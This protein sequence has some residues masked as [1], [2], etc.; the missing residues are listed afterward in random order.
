MTTIPATKAAR[1]ALIGRLLAREAVASQTELS[2]RLASH[3]VR[4]TQATLS[5]DLVELRASKVT[6]PDGAQV[7]AL[8]AQGA[9]GARSAP[10]PP[11]TGAGTTRLGR[12]CAELLVTA[13][14]GGQLA[15]LRTPPGAAQLLASAID[16]AVLPDVLGTIAGDDTVM[17]AARSDAAA[18]A[19]VHQ[20]LDLAGR[21]AEDTKPDD[22]RHSTASPH[23]PKERNNV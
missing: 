4:V 19:L 23:E 14:V 10:E 11:A 8:P 3:G 15:V 16:Q 17:V 13:D 12:W 18:R 1:H 7:Y 21:S 22:D 20:L 9:A 5:R 2:D 6:L